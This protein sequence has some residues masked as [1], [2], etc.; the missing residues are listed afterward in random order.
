MERQ[1]QILNTVII[2]K[3]F[4]KAKVDNQTAYIRLCIQG[5]FKHGPYNIQYTCRVHGLNIQ[6]AT[7]DHLSCKK[8]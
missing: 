5:K 6:T 4:T 3:T 7:F 8:Y 1:F 2:L